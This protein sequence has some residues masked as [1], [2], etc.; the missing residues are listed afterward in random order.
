LLGNGDGTFA[1]AE[2][3]TVGLHPHDLAVGDFNGDGHLDLAV[4]LS[5]IASES[6]TAGLAILLGNGDG[7]FSG[8]TIYPA[9][10]G[11]NGVAVGDFNGDGM[12]DVAVTASGGY[13]DDVRLFLGNGDGTFR[14]GQIASA[15]SGPYYITA[16]DLNGDGHLDLV[17]ANTYVDTVSVLLG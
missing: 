4:A 11:D 3:F 15:G 6:S 8:P 10:G 13:D 1:P 12:L 9:G 7:T 5:G 14:A 2:N 17:T 16:A